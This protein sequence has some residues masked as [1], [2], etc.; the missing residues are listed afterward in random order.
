MRFVDQTVIHVKAGD[1]GH[2]CFAFLREKFRP[3]G[4]PCGGDGGKGGDI[5]YCASNQL[6]TLE[7]LPKNHH[8]KAKNG[9]PGMGRNRTGAGGKN[10]VIHVPQGT[11][12]YSNDKTSLIADLKKTGQELLILNG[13]RG[14]RGNAAF[15]SSTHQSPRNFENGEEG[16]ELWV[17]LRLK[18]IA[19]VG[20]IGLPNA[21]KST[22]MSKITSAKPKIADYP[23]TT[24]TPQ[25]GVVRDQ[26]RDFVIADIPGLIE[27]AHIGVGLGTRF[28]GHIERCS[29]LLHLI[30]GDCENIT[31]SYTSVRKELKLYGCE[32]EKKPEI[33]VQQSILLC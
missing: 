32:L 4:G 26:K 5:I 8:F 27:G 6:S 10:L 11:Q 33:Q 31:T 18:L 17:W 15:K 9:F 20:I 1:G 12:V 16:D 14:G 13:G 30:D 2:G 19:D 25:I 23:F 3:N 22:L 7:D 29:I 24:L 28:L 21:G